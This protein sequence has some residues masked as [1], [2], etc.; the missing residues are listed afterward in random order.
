MKLSILLLK[1]ILSYDA[2]SGHLTYKVKRGE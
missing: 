2:E 1:E